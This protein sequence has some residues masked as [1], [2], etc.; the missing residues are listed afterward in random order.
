MVNVNGAPRYRFVVSVPERKTGIRPP[1]IQEQAFLPEIP[2]GSHPR[3]AVRAIKTISVDQPE[4]RVFFVYYDTGQ[5][6]MF[7][8]TGN[9]F[10]EVLRIT[11]EIADFIVKSMESD[12]NNINV[13]N[14][15]ETT[16]DHE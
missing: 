1:V 11:S 6:A 14:I 10:V 15:N 8:N 4:S 5:T 3:I 12:G 2:A 7:I 16:D 13:I 9:G